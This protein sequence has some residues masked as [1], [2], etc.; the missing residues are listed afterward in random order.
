MFVHLAVGFHAFGLFGFCAS[1]HVSPL[2]RYIRI[3]SV[4]QMRRFAHLMANSYRVSA[5]VVWDLESVLRSCVLIVF[6]GSS[7]YGATSEARR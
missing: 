1:E 5:P 3:D 2:L 7:M 6:V 4:E